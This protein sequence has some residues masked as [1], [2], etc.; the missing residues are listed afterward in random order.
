MKNCGEELVWSGLC[1]AMNFLNEALLKA[2][3]DLIQVLDFQSSHFQTNRQAFSS[4]QSS[5]LICMFLNLFC[6]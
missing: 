6:P 5:L 4:N 1:L 2:L 3:I